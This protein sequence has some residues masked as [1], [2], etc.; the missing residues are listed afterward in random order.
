MSLYVIKAEHF[1]EPTK[2]YVGISENVEHRLDLHFK[3]L[4]NVAW[5]EKF[6]AEGRTWT[7]QEIVKPISVN[8]VEQSCTEYAENVLTKEYMSVHG[9]QN[10]RGGRW[11]QIDLKPFVVE[12]LTMELRSA[13][14]LC[15]SCGLAG[16]QS[17]QCTKNYYKANASSEGLSGTSLWC[18]LSGPYKDTI[19]GNEVLY[20]GQRGGRTDNLVKNGAYFFYRQNSSDMWIPCGTIVEATKICQHDDVSKFKLI[21]GEPKEPIQGKSRAVKSVGL[22]VP[23]RDKWEMSGIIQH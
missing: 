6:S 9:V 3:G 7:L 8:N 2:F 17:R 14:G 1:S 13:S 10:V 16:H 11:S 20:S 22:K 12:E 21:I 18:T 5:V 15:F 23:S 19:N 4:S